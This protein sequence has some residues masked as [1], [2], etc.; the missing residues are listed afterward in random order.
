[1]GWLVDDLVDVFH[2]QII[3]G[4]WD[5]EDVERFMQETN[6]VAWKFRHQLDDEK[7]KAEFTSAKEWEEEKDREVEE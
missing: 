6:K 4:V 5:A 1:M 3:S 2:N 7:K